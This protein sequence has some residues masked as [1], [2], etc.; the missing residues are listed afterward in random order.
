MK[1]GK[2]FGTVNVSCL[3]DGAASDLLPKLVLAEALSLLHTIDLSRLMKYTEICAN[4][5]AC[6]LPISTCCKQIYNDNLSLSKLFFTI[7][8]P[9]KFLVL[10]F[11]FDVKLYRTIE[12]LNKPFNK[13][14]NVALT[15][16]Q[17]RIKILIELIES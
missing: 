15:L 5:T 10:Y 13:L 6:S 9:N 14:I 12:E 4:L 11:I 1:M 3:D 8:V 16:M 17:K 2:G 7:L